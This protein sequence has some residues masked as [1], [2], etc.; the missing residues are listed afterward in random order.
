MTKLV[1]RVLDDASG[2]LLGWVAHQAAIRGDGCLRASAPVIVSIRA[3]GRTG[4]VSVHWAD[5]NTETRWPMPGRAVAPG[6]TLTLF[7]P[8]AVI[9]TVGT[10]PSGLPELVVGRQVVGIPSGGVGATAGA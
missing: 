10:P 2:A 7:E 6:D 9:L 4:A 1:I 5:L 8:H 3:P